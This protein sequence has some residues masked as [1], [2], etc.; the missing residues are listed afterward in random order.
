ML[1]YDEGFDI[2][3]QATSIDW[4]KPTNWNNMSTPLLGST[5]LLV[6][7][8]AMYP[9]SNTREHESLNRAGA[10]DFTAP[11]RYPNIEISQ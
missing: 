3:T 5:K 6:I 4:P 9:E 7:T 8:R 1:I 10:R 11:I 2:V